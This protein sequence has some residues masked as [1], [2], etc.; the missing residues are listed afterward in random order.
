MAFR[1][2]WRGPNIVK[3]G[4]KVYLDASSP[5]SY[6]QL[7][8]STTWKDISGNS[9]TGS[10]VNGPAFSSTSGGYITCDGTND[11]IEVPDNSLLDFGSG[12]FTIEYW[13]RKLRSTNGYSDIWGPNKWNTGASPGTNE[14]TLGIGNG[15]APGNGNNYGFTVEVGTSLYSTGNSVDQLSLNVWYQ[16]IGMREGGSLK[17]YLNSILKQNVSPSGFTESSVINN[18][19]RNLR[20]NNSAVNQYYT[21]C[22]NA[23]FRVYNKALTNQ[24]VLQNYNATRTRFGL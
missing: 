1:Y 23:I 6:A 21:A 19:G 12:N 18:A 13:F 14:W 2:G 9:L 15:S 5:T 7:I 22:D 10:L 8:A 16:L 17:T 4:L 20:I 24:E 11:Y 3:D